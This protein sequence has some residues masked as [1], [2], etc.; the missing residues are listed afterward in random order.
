MYCSNFLILKFINYS[1]W[2]LHHPYQ[3]LRQRDKAIRDQS[4]LAWYE[5]QPNLH[6]IHFPHSAYKK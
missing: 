5:S 2:L 3:R 4:L 6:Q 1:K